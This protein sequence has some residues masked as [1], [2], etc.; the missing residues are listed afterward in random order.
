VIK[1]IHETIAS[2]L[3]TNWVTQGLTMVYK[4]AYLA[5]SYSIPPAFVVNSNQIRI[6]LVFNVNEKT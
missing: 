6:H 4:V 1:T 5:K 3:P 2:K